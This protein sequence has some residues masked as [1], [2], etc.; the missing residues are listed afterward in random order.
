[1]ARSSSRY[2][3]RSRQRFEHNGGQNGNKS[4]SKKIEAHVRFPAVLNMLPFTTLAMPSIDGR[5][6]E[7]ER[8]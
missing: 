3:A 1:M 7:K 5:S 2:L 4:A 8:L 6:T